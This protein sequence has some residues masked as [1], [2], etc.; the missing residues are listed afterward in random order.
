MKAAVLLQKI[1]EEFPD[2]K[3]KHYKLLTHGWDHIVIVLDDRVVF[4][5]PKD[6]PNS[7]LSELPDEVRLLHY[8]NSKVEVGIPEY[9]YV[10]K[11]KSFAG[12]K[13]LNGQEL[14]PSQ[15][16]LFPTRVKEKF[17]E[18]MS[19]FLTALH[20]F[21][22]SSL[23]KYNIRMENPQ[24]NYS[25]FV[26][27]TKKL[28]FPKMNIKE[29]Q[30]IKK[31]FKEL[32]TALNSNYSNT[33]IHNDLTWEHILWDNKKKQAN[34]IDFSDRAFGD[35]AFDFAGL[36]EYGSKFINRVYELYQGKKDNTL[37]HRSLLYYKRIPFFIM[38]GA[39][40][41]HSG[42][43]RDGYLMFKKLYIN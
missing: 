27:K 24:K 5:A 17:A 35:P 4:R 38:N 6:V 39:L 16:N 9:I 31:Y 23:A 40:E 20:T 2:V 13:M 8:L 1:K 12:Y 22:K 32:K 26:C 34:I 43:F 28:V 11:D 3:W 19:D 14:K 29:I 21:Q 37:L 10:S 42:K 7:L 18:Q 15:F 30:I 25:E 33:L 36:W 41:G